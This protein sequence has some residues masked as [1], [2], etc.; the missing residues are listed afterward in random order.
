M[1]LDRSAVEVAALVQSL[2]FAD[3]ADCDA[4]HRAADKRARLAAPL[5]VDGDLAGIVEQY[6]W[7]MS[8]DELDVYERAIARILGEPCRLCGGAELI[9][10][11]ADVVDVAALRVDGGD[12]LELVPCPACNPRARL[13]PSP[14]TSGDVSPRTSSDVSPVAIGD[15]CPVCDEPVVR[16]RHVC[17]VPMP[18]VTLTAVLDDHDASPGPTGDTSP[19]SEPEPVGS[20][21]RELVERAERMA[22]KAAAR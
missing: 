10:G 8:A 15:T 7:P 12:P 13:Q 17:L 11:D 4:R 22:R 16:G 20:R 19:A 6:G 21:A 3:T 1:R 9:A 5:D 14:P 18:G 2:G